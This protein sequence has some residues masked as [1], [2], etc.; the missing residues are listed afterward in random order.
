MTLLCCWQARLFLDPAEIFKSE[1]E[2]AHEKTRKAIEVCTC[3]KE[4]FEEIRKNIQKFFKEG[5]EVKQWEFANELVFTRID[6]FVRRL[7]IVEVSLCK[8]LCCHYCHWETCCQVIQN[9]WST[10]CNSQL[11]ELVHIYNNEFF[12]NQPRCLIKK[13]IRWPFFFPAVS[14]WKLWE[15]NNIFLFAMNIDGSKMYD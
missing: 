8:F 3:F 6:Q 10:V 7:R 1:A 14:P 4:Q 5:Q 2:E 13:R 12:N 15:H 9:L 11:Q